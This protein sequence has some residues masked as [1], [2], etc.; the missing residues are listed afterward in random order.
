MQH[1]SLHGSDQLCS[2]LMLRCRGTTRLHQRPQS[3]WEVKRFMTR[4]T[5]EEHFR[6]LWTFVCSAIM[7]TAAMESD[8]RGGHL[9]H[10]RTIPSMECCHRACYAALKSHMGAYF[11]AACNRSRIF[12][13]KKSFP[14]GAYN[15]C[16]GEK[17]RA[18]R[19]ASWSMYPC[20]SL[21]VYVSWRA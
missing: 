5:C 8:L 20:R 18:E 3:S 19:S 4:I 16:G 2:S 12:C 14:L 6:V 7:A 15:F 11:A 21:T 10:H 13:F 1:W 9:T 17:T